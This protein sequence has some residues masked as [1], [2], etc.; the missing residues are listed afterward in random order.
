MIWGLSEAQVKTLR[1]TVGLLLPALSRDRPPASRNDDGYARMARAAPGYLLD[2][3]GHGHHQLRHWRG[4]DWRCPRR[5]YP[6]SVPRLDHAHGAAAAAFPARRADAQGPR[7][8]NDRAA[9]PR[10]PRRAPRSP[11]DGARQLARLEPGRRLLSPVDQE[12][13]DADE[14][15]G[16]GA[17]PQGRSP[18]TRRAE[19]GQALPARAVAVAAGAE[20]QGRVS[21]R[22]PRP[23]HLAKLW[24]DVGRAGRH[25]HPAEPDAR[26]PAHGPD[27]RPRNG[28]AQ[29]LPLLGGAAAARGL[30]PGAVG[31]GTRA[32]PVSLRRRRTHPRTGQAR[33]D[34][35]DAAALHSRSVVVQTRRRRCS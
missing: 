2:R 8:G 25:Q 21:A 17:R 26:R 12:P 1:L 6:R 28:Q 15:R 30:H 3:R 9:A 20:G 13:A 11:R 31:G 34:D 35:G 27:P 16:I 5:P 33:R 14:P 32:R 29:D 18:G 7:L 4:G 22:P 23:S 24:R 10:A 19:P